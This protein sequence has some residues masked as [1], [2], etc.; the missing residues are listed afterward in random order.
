MDGSNKENSANGLF[1]RKILPRITE[2]LDTPGIILLIG[3]R[4]VG[5]TSIMSLLRTE[6]AKRAVPDDRIRY[7]DLED[8]GL[9]EILNKGVTEFLSYLRAGG[10]DLTKNS[11]VFIDEIQY[12]DNPSNFLKLM[13]DHH[14]NVKLIVSGSSTLE[15]RRKFKDS[16]A[17]RKVVFEVYPLDFQE[18]LVFRG[19]DQLSK[20]VMESDIRHVRPGVA[21]EDIPARFYTEVLSGYFREYLTYG[22]YPGVVCEPVFEKKIMYLSDIYNSYVKK[23]IKDLMRVDNITAFNNLLKA[24]AL[25]TGSLVNIS[26]LCAAIMTARETV[27]R[28]LAILENT[29]IIKT[30]TPFSGNPRKEISKMSKL[31][32]TDTG[33]RNII[34]RNFNPLDER[35]DAGALVESGVCG[36]M[37]KN[38]G[39][40]EEMHFWRT[41]A[42]NEVDFIISEGVSLRPVEVKYTAFRTPKVPSGIRHFQKDYQSEDALVLTKDY[43]GIADRALFL[44]VWLC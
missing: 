31:F 30:I 7:I 26:E 19:E 27:E 12:M 11:F 36:N 22:G 14:K 42:K 15:I 1:P 13:A 40:L 39:L 35:V 28:Y 17:G 4:Q 25:Q 44:P 37:L 34:I 41:L 29:F 20:I 16:L 3:A 43:Y 24:L 9:L 21:V 2:Y 32:F 38:R 33:L 18:F 5:K 6:L 10:V 8:L 23:D